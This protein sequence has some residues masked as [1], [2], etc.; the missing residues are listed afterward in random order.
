VAGCGDFEKKNCKS[1]GAWQ[2]SETQAN[3][4]KSLGAWQVSEIYDNKYKSLGMWQV[5]ETF[6][7]K[8]CPQERGRFREL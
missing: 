2:V 1:L 6:G 8:T 4:Y 5:M 7:K 3:K